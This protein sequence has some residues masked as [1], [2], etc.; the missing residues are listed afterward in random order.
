M[1]ITLRVANIQQR[2][3]FFW[4]VIGFASVSICNEERI[5]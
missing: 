5:K 4:F 3:E 1:R 2:P